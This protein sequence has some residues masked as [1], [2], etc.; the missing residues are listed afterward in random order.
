MPRPASLRASDVRAVFLLVG[1]CRELGDDPLAWRSHLLSGVA[2]LTGA[3]LAINYEGQW[4]PFQP[5]SVVDWG[6]QNGF[7][8]AVWVRMNEEFHRQG[9][10]FNPM[11][12]P[13]LDAVARGL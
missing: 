4:E 3:G 9:L 8:H 13:Y 2:G 10:G 5:T 11:F 12:R 7:D 1:E 6:W